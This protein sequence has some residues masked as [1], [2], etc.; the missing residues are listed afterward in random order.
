[1]PDTAIPDTRI[2]LAG[3]WISVM[4]TFLL[5]DVLRI[6]AGHV[7][8]GKIKD[9][10]P[11]QGVWLGIAVLMVVPIVLV[12]LTLILPYPAIRWINI[13]AA[14]FWIIFNLIGLPYEG[15]YDNFLIVVS[16]IFNLIT[17]YFA[18]NWVI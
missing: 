3:I 16:I 13:I 4:L 12:V 18:W 1:M 11:S 10:E 17:I 14:V 9:L 2:I 15:A 7:E 8:P 6:F 5:G